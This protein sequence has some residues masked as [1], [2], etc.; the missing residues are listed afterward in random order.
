MK[1]AANVEAN[2][3][4]PKTPRPTAA[5]SNCCSAMNI[6]K[7]RS[8]YAF[9]NSSACVELDTSASS[10]HVGPSGAKGDE[11]V[12]VS[13]ARRLFTAERVRRRFHDRGGRRPLRPTFLRLRA[14][15]EDVPLAAQLGDGLLGLVG[16]HGLAVPAVLIGDERDAA[17]LDRLGDEDSRL[18]LLL[19]RFGIGFVD[20]GEVVAVE[21]DGVPTEARARA[22]YTGPSQPRSV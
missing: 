7:K 12:A 13:L 1:K 14:L 17:A 4:L 3:R 21:F 8:G 18:I 10:H 6:S 5:P 2:G 15:D 20:C 22:A 9:L 16:A 11:S 19:Q